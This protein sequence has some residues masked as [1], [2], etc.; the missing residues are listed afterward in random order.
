MIDSYDRNET[1]SDYRYNQQ[2]HPLPFMK[3]SQIVAPKKAPAK[4]KPDLEEAFE[5]SEDDAMDDAD[6]KAEDDDEVDLS[7]DKYV[8]QP[9]KK[10]A[11]TAKAGGA[12]KKKTVKDEDD[13]EDEEDVKPKKGKGKDR[14][15][16]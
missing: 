15:K 10:K 5:E 6:V 2:S 9:K 7:K 16:K 12:K 8:K 1:D 3:A 13:E 4:E 11:T 14:A